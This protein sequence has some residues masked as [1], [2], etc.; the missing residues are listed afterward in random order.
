M[1]EYKKSQR[2]CLY[3]HM[4]EEVQTYSIL[5][6]LLENNK[7]CFIPQYIGMSIDNSSVFHLVFKLCFSS[8]SI[9]GWSCLFFQFAVKMP[10]NVLD[11]YSVGQLLLEF[12]LFVLIFCQ[13]PC[14]G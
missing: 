7:E 14:I 10:D 6:N 8:V 9:I 2:V 3:L 12:A 13:F 1:T 11:I 5:Q 4:K